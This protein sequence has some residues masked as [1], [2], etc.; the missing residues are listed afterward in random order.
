MGL[1]QYKILT[2][3]FHFRDKNESKSRNSNFLRIG[4]IIFHFYY[5]ARGHIRAQTTIGFYVS[6]IKMNY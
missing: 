6:D 5:S 3:F 1:I 4:Y 2:F